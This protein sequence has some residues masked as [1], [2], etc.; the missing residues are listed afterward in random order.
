MTALSSPEGQAETYVEEP[1]GFWRRIQSFE[2][3]RLLISHV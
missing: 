3:Y 2:E 1:G